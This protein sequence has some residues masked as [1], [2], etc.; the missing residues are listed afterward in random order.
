MTPVETVRLLIA[1]AGS[2]VFTDD[3]IQAFLDLE[4]QSIRLA[5]ADGLMSLAAL[6]AA[7]SQKLVVLDITLDTTSKPEQ[8]RELAKLMIEQ[9]SDSAAF[10]FGE[11]VDSPI[12]RKSVV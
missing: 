12:D 11:M 2:V 7:G 10:A 1:D 9:E 4:D 5:A 8:L 3:D 6:Y